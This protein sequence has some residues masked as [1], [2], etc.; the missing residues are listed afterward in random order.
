[1][2]ADLV[3]HQ[4]VYV[5]A[6]DLYGSAFYPALGFLIVGDV[7][8]EPAPFYPTRVH[9]VEHTRPVAT[10]RASGAR[11]YG[12]KRAFLVV[13]VGQQFYY[14]KLLVF[15][16]KFRKLRAYVGFLIVGFFFFCEFE[17]IRKILNVLS[18]LGPGFQTVTRTLY[19][20]H[21]FFRAV[22]V[23][24]ETFLAAFVFEFGNL[25]F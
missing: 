24:P 21:D 9:A 23:V 13:L 15:F 19:V 5:I 17:Q 1:V 2:N 11:V 20:E 12:N 7:V 25:S 16:G 22:A 14:M 3:F 18:E 6:L 4:T 8:L 10:F